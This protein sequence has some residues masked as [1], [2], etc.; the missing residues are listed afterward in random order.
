VSSD[1]S[2]Q[3]ERQHL[4]FVS[5]ASVRALENGGTAGGPATRDLRQQMIDIATRPRLAAADQRS[6]LQESAHALTVG[7]PRSLR[8]LEK[9]VEESQLGCRIRLM[10]LSGKVFERNRHAMIG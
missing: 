4:F 6:A 9:L 1:R 5:R 2:A 10:S 3:L 8:V 7:D